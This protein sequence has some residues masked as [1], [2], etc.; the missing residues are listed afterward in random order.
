MT[1]FLRPLMAWDD[2]GTMAASTAAHNNQI[3]NG[4]GGRGIGNGAQQSQIVIG[5]G[6]ERDGGG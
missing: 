6:G 3:V 5:R 1:P 2:S 4:R